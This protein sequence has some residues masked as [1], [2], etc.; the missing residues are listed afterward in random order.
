VVIG[1]GYGFE[2]PWIY[3]LYG[4]FQGSGKF[5]H[6]FKSPGDPAFR[7]VDGKKPSPARLKGLAYGVNRVKYF[8]IQVW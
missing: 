1:S 8:R 6:F 3:C 5:D 7:N 4:N 2:Q